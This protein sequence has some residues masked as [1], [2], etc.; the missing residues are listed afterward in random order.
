VSGSSCWLVWTP[1]ASR[2]P[3]HEWRTLQEARHHA[4]GVGN[5]S[6]RRWGIS[7]ICSIPAPRA[8]CAG[9]C[10]SWR[11]RSLAC[12][13]MCPPTW[14][15]MS[16][17][18]GHSER[19]HVSFGDVRRY[20]VHSSHM[21]DPIQDTDRRFPVV[22]FAM[23]GRDTARLLSCCRHGSRH[24]SVDRHASR[25]LG[26]S[27]PSAAERENISSWIAQEV[28]ERLPRERLAEAIADYEA[29]AGAIT[30]ADI[31]AA[32]AHATWDPSLQ[33]S[34]PLSA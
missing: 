33:R 18:T 16:T 6:D 31:A 32:R 14:C 15:C 17:I 5:F 22:C 3:P 13:D 28:A 2:S 23:C 12:S 30:D 25:R 34:K 21:W 20:I 29:K 8:L 26:R 19:A 4:Q 7:V 1:P 9:P 24:A 10:A 11:T 27:R